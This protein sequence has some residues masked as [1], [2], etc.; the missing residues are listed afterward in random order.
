MKK[1]LTTCQFNSEFYAYHK[2]PSLTNKLNQK[3]QKFNFFQFADPTAPNPTIP[4]ISPTPVQPFRL[5][6]HGRAVFITDDCFA[7]FPHETLSVVLS[8][9]ERIKNAPTIFSRI[10]GRPGLMT[11]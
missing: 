3:D 11:W 10:L 4:S 5:F 2:V 7:D 1:P 6:P 9:V 8:L